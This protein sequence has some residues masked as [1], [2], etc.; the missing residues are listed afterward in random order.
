MRRIVLLCTL[1]ALLFGACSFAAESPKKLV[2]LAPLPAGLESTKMQDIVQGMVTTLAKKIS[3]DVVIRKIPYKQGEKVA[4]EVRKQLEA[5]KADISFMSGTDYAEAVL[6][7][8]KGLVPMFIM[9]INQNPVTNY[10]LYARKGE[11]TDVTQMKGKKWGGVGIVPTRYLLSTKGV[12]SPLDK[13]FSSIRFIQDSPPNNIVSL[14]QK[15]E[16]DVFISADTGIWLSGMLRQ[17]DAIFEPVYCAPAETNIIFIAR[18]SLDGALIEELKKIMFNA[19]KDKDFAQFKF[20]FQMVNGKFVPVDQASLQ[21]PMK[22]MK[23]AIKNGWL[24]EDMA[25]F[26]K[27]IK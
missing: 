3:A 13:Y 10:C 19:H 21:V 12:N 11:F 24:K 9:T 5:G 8:S 2:F 26:N 6:K 25:F 27:Y 23:L 20:A 15:K 1:F 22:V 17:K 16:I 14:L 7:G 18:S 4:Y